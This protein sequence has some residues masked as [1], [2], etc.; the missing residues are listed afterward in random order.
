MVVAMMM[1]LIKIV[2]FLRAVIITR[3]FKLA[4]YGEWQLLISV[5]VVNAVK[6]PVI[7]LIGDIFMMMMMMKMM[8]CTHLT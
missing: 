4:D 5:D 7:L 6:L 1:I 3:Y 8:I 2:I